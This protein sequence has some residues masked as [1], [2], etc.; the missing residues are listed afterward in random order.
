MADDARG[1]QFGMEPSPNH[2]RFIDPNGLSLDD[3]ADRLR[4]RGHIRQLIELARDED[5][6]S[7]THDW[8]GELMF[9]PSDQRRIVMRA[10]E[11]GIVSGLTFLRDILEV[12]DPDQGVDSTVEARDGD[13]IKPGDILAAFTGNARTIVA[14]ERTMLN[15]ISRM[16]GIATRTRSFV[17]C[18]ADTE[19]QVCD[20]RKTTPGLRDF[21]KFAVRCGGGTTHRMGL[22]DAVLIK[23]N[24][25]AGLAGD[26]LKTKIESL[27]RRVNQIRSEQGE[28]LWFVQIEVDRMDQFEQVLDAEPGSVDMVLLDNMKPAM[29]RCAVEM[30]DER[31]SRIQLEASGGVT[32]ETVGEIARSGVDRISIGGLTHQATSLDFGFDA[33][34]P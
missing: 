13:R 16:S 4:Q 15:L 25:L 34:E 31:G 6:G 33:D 26:D 8:T 22:N 7:P 9:A 14:F 12:F 10:R 28:E 17:D 19:A 3:F 23:D 20:T 11:P 24:H 27:A 21:E 2:S 5:L 29:L 30:R 1:V 18:V 32:M